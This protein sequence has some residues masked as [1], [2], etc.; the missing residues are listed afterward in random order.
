MYPQAHDD[1]FKARDQIR[2][3]LGNEW[4]PLL[5]AIDG[6]FGAGKSG[7]ASWLAWQLNMA[8][9]HLDLYL[10]E[11]RRWRISELRN[12]I[13]ARI[14]RTSRR[15]PVIVEGVLVLEAL[16]QANFQH[17]FFIFVENPAQ[18]DPEDNDHELRNNFSRCREVADCVVR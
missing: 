14:K 5:I 6:A 18:N 11:G 13:D 17:D 1:Y 4:L 10:L 3:K 7:L 8:T 2:E 15:L 9:I 12:A 16:R